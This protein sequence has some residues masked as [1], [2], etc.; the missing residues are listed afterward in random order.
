M[1]IRE[2]LQYLDSKK[3][4]FVF[5]GNSESEIMGFCPIT[6]L[7][8]NSITWARSLDNPNLVD[9]CNVE[10]LLLVLPEIVSDLGMSNLIAT[11]N[12]HSVYFSILEHFFANKIME[13]SIA[14][15]AVVESTNIGMNISIGHHS[16]IGK[17]VIIGNDVTIHNN[18]SITGS[19]TIGDNT[20]IY[21]GVDIGVDG[22]GYFTDVEGNHK[23]VPHLGGVKIGNDV[24]IG[25]NTCI[26]RGCLGDTIIHD[27]VKID[28]LCHIAHNVEIGR[29]SKVIALSL[30]AGSCVIGEDVWIAPGSMIKNQVIVGDKSLV[31]MGSVV[32]KNVPEN[33]V[34]AGVPA[35]IIRDNN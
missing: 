31:G 4:N 12:P 11:E 32:T 9:V 2:I 14:Y 33:K 27:G 21:S 19:V 17:N 3:V 13:T 7:K 10:N 5:H 28:N 26:A 29:N 30:I 15:T 23:R 24:E 6:D 22:Y 25:A 16:Y 34:V 35:K 18:V 8:T 20:V 1:K